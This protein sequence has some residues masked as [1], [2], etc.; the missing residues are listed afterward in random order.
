MSTTSDMVSW[1]VM[2]YV[3][4]LSNGMAASL[5]QQ[6]TGRYFPA[7]YHTS[8]VVHSREIFFGQGIDIARPGQTHHG[9]PLETHLLGETS[10]DEHTLM[11]LVDSMKE[12]YS[13]Q[14]YHLLNFNCNNFSDELAEILT[15]RGIPSHITSLPSDFLSTP[16]GQMMAP[17]IDSM[18]R[19]PA[20]RSSFPPSPANPTSNSAPPLAQQLLQNVANQATSDQAA[21]TSALTHVG[22]AEG[23]REVQGVDD[24]GRLV[25]TNECAVLYFTSDTCPPCALVKPVIA[26]AA[27]QYSAASSD[28][29]QISFGLVNASRASGSSV[30][31]TYGVSVT[32]TTLFFLNGN[33]RAEVKGADVSEVQS[34]TDLL[35]FE[36]WQAHP[37]TQIRNLAPLPVPGS[38]IQFSTKPKLDALLTK[39]DSFV[40]ARLLEELASDEKT[41]LSAARKSVREQVAAW[42]SKVESKPALPP[43]LLE[44]WSDAHTTLLA[45][46]QPAQI[47]PLLDLLRLA[48]LD[49]QFLSSLSRPASRPHADQLLVRTFERVSSFTQEDIASPSVRATMLTS[50]RLLCNTL[51]ALGDEPALASMLLD[52]PA[53]TSLTALLSAGL[54]YETSSPNSDASKEADPVAGMRADQGIALSASSAAFNL[55][56]ILSR[57]NARAGWL[58]RDE[59]PIPHRF[60]LHSGQNGA[61]EKEQ[62]VAR[63]CVLDGEWEG[64]MLTALLHAVVKACE[65]C[66]AEKEGNSSTLTAWADVLHR[67][68]SALLLLLHKSQHCVESLDP[69]AQVLEAKGTIRRVESLAKGSIGR[70]NVDKEEKKRWESVRVGCEKLGL[71]L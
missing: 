22:S 8:I 44:G 20:Q 43:G 47:F 12:R 14:A 50:L 45:L 13:A 62:T 56:L 54:L 66:E 23:L 2:L 9:A 21:P 28:P 18:F 59:K 53:C 37:H 32:P 60:I 65:T 17:Q 36:V 40:S 67:Q 39:L 51:A 61:V 29:R 55:F 70:A 27:E 7:I 46:L 3:Y 24:A 63:E 41:T 35:A 31:Q 34:Q 4:D 52:N 64:E 11:E 10:V 16:F 71:I 19:G 58:R 57:T 68:I 69:L 49:A 25:R 48:L 26:R 30:F 38:P 15:G 1:P 5:S 6:L 33:R 42:L